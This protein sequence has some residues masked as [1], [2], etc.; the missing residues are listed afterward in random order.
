[1]Q[2]IFRDEINFLKDEL[3]MRGYD[4]K[5]Y[6][7]NKRNLCS[8]NSSSQIMSNQN[9]FSNGLIESSTTNITI[10]NGNELG[11][12]TVKLLRSKSPDPST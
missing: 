12:S 4:F 8:S 10:N 9:S 2:E 1:M 11:V 6:P 7:Y 5:D 3:K